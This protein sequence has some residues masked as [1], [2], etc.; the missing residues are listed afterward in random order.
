MAS[1]KQLAARQR[2]KAMVQAKQGTKKANDD[3]A[4]IVKN[5][6]KV[7]TAAKKAAKKKVRRR[8]K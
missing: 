4:P 6:A 2:F 8:R 7:A 5:A 3:G 1:P